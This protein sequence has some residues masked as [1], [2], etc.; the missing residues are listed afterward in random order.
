MDVCIALALSASVVL[1]LPSPLTLA[2]EHSVERFALEEDYVA[3]AAGLVVSE[4]RMR[5][6]GAGVDLP[7]HAQLVGG[8]WRYAPAL[9]PQP[10][11]VLA[12]SRWPAGYR[13]CHGS[14]CETLAELAG[15]ADQPLAL[16]PCAP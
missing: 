3:T 6:L 16:A 5:G 9:G 4:V 12:N 10:R 14:R 1:R 2:W 11:I 15:A 8:W 13:A 7:A